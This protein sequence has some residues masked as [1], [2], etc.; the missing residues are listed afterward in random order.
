M[1]HAALP[2]PGALFELAADRIC[3]VAAEEWPSESVT[4]GAHVPS[5]TGYVRRV[6]L[7]GREVF[8]KDSV[9][10]LSLVSV[11]R[12]VAGDGDQ[13]RAA[14]AAYATSPTS[15]LA[16]EAAQLRALD[17]AGIRVGRCVGYRQGVL[18]TEAVTG[19][20][21]LDLI[22]KD[23]ARAADLMSGAVRS[24][25]SLQSPAVAAVADEAAIAERGI[26]TTFRRKFNG[27]SG[28][29]Y[30]ARL[31]VDL[32]EERTRRGAV[33]VLAVVVSRLLKLRLTPAPGPRMVV[34]GDLKPEH[35]LFPD[36]PDEQPVFIDPGLSRGGSHQDA[37]KLASRAL[38]AVIAASPVDGATLVVEGIDAFIREQ[39]RGIGRTER[40]MWL[41]RLMV[42]WLM[43]SVNIV[44]TYLAAPSAL[45]LPEHAQAVVDSAPAL[46]QVLDSVS[47][48]LTAGTEP[49]SAWRLALACVTRAATR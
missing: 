48:T 11:L 37:A 45:P 22:A 38:L 2:E 31:G 21:L 3:R 16:R 5:V 15:L 26:D 8:A 49:E 7:G 30:V 4:L 6:H 9:L 46:C 47:A 18:F 35:V 42:T 39:Y 34:Y 13:V 12:G 43:D 28:R 41:R 23:P 1:P 40:G 10:G 19:P 27:I 44:S 33:A 20:N 29:A 25:A 14:Q 17:A 36:G 32:L 24:L